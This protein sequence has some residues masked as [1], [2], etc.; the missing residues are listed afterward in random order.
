MHKDI[1]SATADGNWIRKLLLR[2]GT[3]LLMVK[4]ASMYY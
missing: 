3:S 2:I 1:A 4:I